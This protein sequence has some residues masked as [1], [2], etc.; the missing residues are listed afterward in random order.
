MLNYRTLCV[1]QIDKQTSLYI[2]LVISS[3]QN[4]IIVYLSIILFNEVLRQTRK[5]LAKPILNYTCSTKL[6]ILDECNYN[7]Q[8]IF[9]INYCF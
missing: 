9:F 2:K 8:F 7:S 4:F 6:V 3:T 1:E 5:V